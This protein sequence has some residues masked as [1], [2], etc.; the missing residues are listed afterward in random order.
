M[1]FIILCFWA[2]R[3][4]FQVFNIVYRNMNLPTLNI[5]HQIGEKAILFQM[6]VQVIY[7]QATVIWY[8]KNLES[9]ENF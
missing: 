8:F 7:G 5:L 2:L 4:F 3:Y 6:H 9:E 1:G